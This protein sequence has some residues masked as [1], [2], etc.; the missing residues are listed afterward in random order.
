[1]SYEFYRI[2]H[3][4]G[5]AAFFICV[6]ALFQFPYLSE[7]KKIPLKKFW[8]KIHGAA[9]LL[10]ILGGF[11]MYARLALPPPIPHWIWGKLCIWLFFGGSLTLFIRKPKMAKLTLLLILLCAAAAFT[12]VRYKP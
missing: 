7:D 3:F 6:G 5:L 2:L 4:T 9:L 1:M 12:L 11:G 8:M 10:I